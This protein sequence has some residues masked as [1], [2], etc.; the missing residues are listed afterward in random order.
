V[1]SVVTSRIG[2][3][4]GAVVVDVEVDVETDRW[5]R[6][7]LEPAMDV[8]PFGQADLVVR[9]VPSDGGDPGIDCRMPATV[10]AVAC[11]GLDSRMVTLPGWR[12]GDALIVAD[13]RHSCRYRI[14]D[15]TID[16]LGVPG[17]RRSRVGLMRVVR[18]L[19]TAR[20]AAREPILDLHASAFEVEGQAVLLAGPKY[21][22]KTTALC[23]ALTSGRTRLIANDRVFVDVN[24]SGAQA[25]GVPTLIAVRPRTAVWFPALAGAAPTTLA[26]GTTVSPL[27]LATRLGA[28]CV[29]GGRVRSIVFPEIVSDD[30]DWELAPMS[31]AEGAAALSTSLYGSR[32]DQSVHSVFGDAEVPS[33]SLG[34]V[35]AL[36]RQVAREVRFFRC[37]LGPRA[38]ARDGD[39]WLRALI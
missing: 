13:A 6:S 16:V 19:L 9:L 28:A 39:E 12:E 4:F 31:E 23:Y 38:Y 2:Y 22:G 15:R 14:R 35:G 30:R 3:A 34:D 24:S 18:E 29:R 33:T 20:R 17:D 1:T 8:R 21:S 37:R 26:E 5:L 11:F 7:F 25:R 27:E 32:R 36:S 10:D